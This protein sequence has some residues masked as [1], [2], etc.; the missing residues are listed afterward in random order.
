MIQ[1]IDGTA[2]IQSPGPTGLSSHATHGSAPIP[3]Q[4][5][6]RRLWTPHDYRAF[7]AVG[8]RTF[9]E[10]EAKGLLAEARM[11][12]PRLKRYIPEECE[13]KA[14]AMPKE[15]APEPAQLARARIERMKAGGS[16]QAGA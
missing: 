2:G 4:T 1:A 16:V 15:R 7:L 11:F 3:S 6:G 9:L 5:A 8:E 13:A 14:L 10:M 12:G